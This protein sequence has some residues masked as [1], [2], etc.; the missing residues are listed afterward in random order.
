[1]RIVCGEP[2]KVVASQSLGNTD[3]ERCF[4]DRQFNVSHS[5]LAVYV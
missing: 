4:L 2:V 5:G 3:F 1:M